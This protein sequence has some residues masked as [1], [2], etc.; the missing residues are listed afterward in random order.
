MDQSEDKVIYRW[1]NTDRETSIVRSSE[2]EHAGC[3]PS[4]PL[5]Q[6]MP[7]ALP[8]VLLAPPPE[9]GAPCWPGGV[10]TPAGK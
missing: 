10:R 3:S 9:D 5:N 1:G 8:R 6:S 7:G 2:P 4:G